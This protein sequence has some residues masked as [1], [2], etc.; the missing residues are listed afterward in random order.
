MAEPDVKAPGG[1]KGTVK[2]FGQSM[3]KKTLMIAA[4]VGAGVLG[5]AYYSKRKNASSGTAAAGATGSI[6]PA[7]GY[8]YGS[9]EDTAALAAQSGS[10]TTGGYGGID[11]LTGLPYGS[12]QDQQ[13]LQDS[14][15]PVGATGAGSTSST[16]P[17]A[18][19]VTNAEWEQE[20]IAN[21]EAGGVDQATI[22]N[23]ESG[24]PRYLAHLTMSSAQGTAV[25]LAVGLTGPPPSGG[26]YSIRIA[27]S[28]PKPPPAAKV[29]IPALTGERVENANSAL[30]SLGL[31][32]SFGSR[33]PGVAYTVTATSPKAGTEVAK[34]STVHL[35]I[36]EVLNTPIPHERG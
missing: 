27:P 4:L 10:G 3:S 32:S 2:I 28:P 23:A 8:P 22:S 34:G 21:L 15:F 26:P 24:L 25:Q 7:T 30:Q 19:T 35:S 31:K 18:T 17:A 11:P 9:A 6:D 20:C 5:Y 16:S 33:K 12:V 1:G 29:R 14:G 13:A 36:R